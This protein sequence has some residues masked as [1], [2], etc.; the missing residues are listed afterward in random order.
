MGNILPSMKKSA[1]GDYVSFRS[2]NGLLRVNEGRVTYPHCLMSRKSLD[3]NNNVPVK[4]RTGV[5]D[6]IVRADVLDSSFLV[7]VA[8]LEADLKAFNNIGII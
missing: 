5:E 3:V 2:L 8:D 6:N 1:K 7:P 4:Q